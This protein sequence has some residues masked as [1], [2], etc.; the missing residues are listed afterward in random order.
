MS[1]V[2]QGRGFT[3]MEMLV[4]V[5]LI[6]ILAAIAVPSYREYVMRTNRTVAKAALAEI[7]SRQEGY[8]V[9]HKGYA[10]TFAA[11]GIIGTGAATEA[12]VNPQGEIT[13]NNANALYRLTLATTGGTGADMPTCA[14]FTAA[15]DAA[16][17]RLAFRVV[18]DPVDNNSDTRCGNLC[19]SSRGDRGAQGPQTAVECWGR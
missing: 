16:S 14:G 11:L 8:A 1:P 4:V 17:V 9:D 18:A 10:A 2:T 12:F 5:V 7:V 15:S 19:V 6:S 13:R 3:I